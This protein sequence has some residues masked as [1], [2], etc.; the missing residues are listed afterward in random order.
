MFIEVR[1]VDALE[2]DKM[3]RLEESNWWY[4]G[5]RDIVL[6][7]ADRIKQ[8]G[9]FPENPMRILDAGCGT[10]LNLKYLQTLGESVGLDISEDALGFSR[11]RGLRSLICASADKLPLMSK[12]FDLVLA[13]DVIEH[14]EDDDSV[15]REFN[16][17][18]RPGG[19][20]IVTV[21]AFMSLWSEHDVAV[22]HKRRYALHELIFILKSG[23]FRI[24]WASH[25]NF[26]LFLPVFGMRLLKRHSR[27]K[28]KK[29][30]DLIELPYLINRL[31]LGLLKLENSIIFKSNFP[32][33]VS[34]IC[35][36][37][38]E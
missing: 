16:R 15:I 26:V 17:V 31:L 35:V 3:Y 4:A 2:Y 24:E 30:T 21:P 13:L 12:A 28:S 7:I 10:G 29:Q 25:W 19:W 1:K 23:G 36:C 9:S 32:F 6:K 11:A 18:L 20:L 14:I 33:G 38:K 22:H 27:S 5:R 34:L 37:K 8:S